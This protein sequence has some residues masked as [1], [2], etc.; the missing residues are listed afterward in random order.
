MINGKL[1][2]LVGLLT[3]SYNTYASLASISD[4]EG[5]VYINDNE[6]AEIDI[7][8]NDGDKI[9]T[10]D[11]SYVEITFEDEHIIRLQENTELVIRKKA[12]SGNEVFL[13]SGKLLASL[14]NLVKGT[15]FE[16]RTPTAVAAVKGTDFAVE[17]TEQNTAIGVFEGE[18]ET[19]GIDL[20]GKETERI[21]VKQNQ[22]TSV[23]KHNKPVNPVALKRFLIYREKIKQAREKIRLIRQ[24]KQSGE[25]AKRRE[26]R[27]IIRANEVGTWVDK[28]PE[29]FQKLPE[30]KK[31][32]IRMHI[33][34][35]QMHPKELEKRLIELRKNHPKEFQAFQKKMKQK[36]EKQ[37]KPV[38]KLKRPMPQK[39]PIQKRPIQ[40]IRKGK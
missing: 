2:V 24:L 11:N 34:R 1:I 17:V 40:P 21:F 30:W 10:K 39:K 12:E 37:Q 31:K 18:V 13:N 27:A 9:I 6:E 26:M 36:L 15:S 25:L 4:L 19:A 23:L 28:N 8:L 5:E 7:E 16:V 38:P 29:S 32:R 22:E 20:Q 33:E 35:Y 3:V 14:K